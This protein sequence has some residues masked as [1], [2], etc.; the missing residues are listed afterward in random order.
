MMSEE[1]VNY[2]FSV[3]KGMVDVSSGMAWSG[4]VQSSPTD[5]SKVVESNG[6]GKGVSGLSVRESVQEAIL[7]SLSLMTQTCPQKR[8]ALVTF[9]D[10]N[11]RARS[12]RARTSCVDISIDSI[13][14]TWVK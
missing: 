6:G 7:K 13:K 3:K 11:A 9:N 12:N 2:W 5:R 4:L 8:V 1:V 14:E 10:E